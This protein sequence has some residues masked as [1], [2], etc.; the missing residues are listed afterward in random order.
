MS[1]VLICIVEKLIVF[2]FLM[3]NHEFGELLLVF[4]LE[5]IHSFGFSQ[6]VF[7]KNFVKNVLENFLFL[8]NK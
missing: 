3:A 8:N 5:Q 6:N 7:K 1:N 2:V 4:A